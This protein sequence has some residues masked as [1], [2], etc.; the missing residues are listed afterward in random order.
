LRRLL[1]HRSARWR[2]GAVRSVEAPISSAAGC[3]DLTGK[4]RTYAPR[5]SGS[6]GV[7]YAFALDNNMTLT[8]RVDYAHISR[9]WGVLFENNALGD[10]LDQ[11]DVFNAQVSLANG[12]WQRIAYGANV[13]DEMP[14]Q[15][16]L[17]CRASSY[18]PGLPST[19]RRR[20]AC[21]RL[22]RL[23]TPGKRVV[24]TNWENSMSTAKPKAKAARPKQRRTKAEQ[25]ADTV[26]QILNG[27]EEL[28]GLRGPYGVTL[29][30]VAQK[31]GVPTSLLHYYFA[32]KDTLFDA[33]FARRA[34]ITRELRM[35]ALDRYEQE[36]GGKPTVEGVLRVFLDTDLNLYSGNEGWRNFAAL[37]AQASV[38]RDWGTKLFDHHFDGVV[39]K[40]IGILRRALPECSEED[41]FWCY[42]FTSGALCITLAQTGRIDTL[43]GG[44]CDS[45]DFDAAK[46]RMASF[47][48]GGFIEV[49]RQRA[50]QKKKRSRR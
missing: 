26:E 5:F 27:A 11:W 10:H 31:V 43:S 35:A 12:P 48:A 37:G 8:H 28:F 1:W 23:A 9:A 6:I 25:R 50:A 32:D 36:C 33:V 42:Q 17:N 46:Q 19:N 44:L 45:E 38:A 14:A 39:L 4:Q 3:I 18:F 2:H 41:L 40:L 22:A 29:K 7:A 34:A 21:A 30:D 24:V 13:T 20:T 49:V 15:I 47:I 16:P